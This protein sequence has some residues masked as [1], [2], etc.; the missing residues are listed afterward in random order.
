MV[1]EKNIIICRCNDIALEDLKK[2]IEEGV[3]DFELLRKYL[4]IGFG[5]C[6]GRSC[7]MIAARWFTR[8]TGKSMNEVLK[9]YRVRPPIIPVP[10]YTLVK[11]DE[12]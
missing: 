8:L 4:R 1:G 12:L 3:D 2:T 10:L 6:Q 9:E 11:G 7:I 5:P